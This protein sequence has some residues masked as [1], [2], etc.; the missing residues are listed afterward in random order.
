MKMKRRYSLT[1]LIGESFKSLWRNGAMS[2][3]SITVLMSCLIVIGGFSLIIFNINEN[4]ERLGLMNEMVAF[5]DYKL[6]DEEIESV[7]DQINKLENIHQVVHITKDEALE[8]MKEKAGEFGDV[9]AELEG[10]E[11]P[12]PDTFRVTYND[13]SKASTLYYQLTQIDGIYKVNN[14]LNVANTIESIKNGISL[15]GIW[16]L[17]ILL[18]VSIFVIVNTIK[19]AVFARRTEI[20]IMR[21]IGASS[22][23]ITLPFIFEGIIIGL[24][25]S[26]IAYLLVWLI[27]G[28]IENNAG[29]SIQMISLLPFTEVNMIVLA[30]FGII[31][32]LTG[33]I[34]SCASLRKYLKA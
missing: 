21:Y 31:G 33:I 9:Y 15:V 3:A 28:Y 13:N 32:V 2:L 5:A 34:G 8:D 12:L 18:I 14:R 27:Y 22:W 7:K 10:D 26:G 23:F 17:A 16:F 19:L 24:V 6:T 25:S 4:V 11:N 30:G 29:A 1:Y 20:E